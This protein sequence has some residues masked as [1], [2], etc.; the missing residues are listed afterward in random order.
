MSTARI[1]G[2]FI[3]QRYPYLPKILVADTNPWWQNKTAVK[4]DY[5]SGGVAPEYTHTDWGGVYD[6]L[7]GGIVDGE[8]E[9][10]VD[11]SKRVNGT[12]SDLTSW[13]PL[14][15]IHPTNQWFSGGPV[16]LASA[17][18]GDRSWLTF[19]ASQSGHADYPPNPPIPWWNCRRGW[20]PVELMYAAG[21]KEGTRNRRRPVLDNEPHYENRYNNG[22]S[23]N[24]YWNASDIRV[25]SWQT[26]SLGSAVVLSCYM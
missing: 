21:E 2:N 1:F 4:A 8:H 10:A 5:T 7:A 15:T 22:K 16:A 6:E 20:E 18:L 13:E 12:Q 19:D 26:V 17:F 3:G 9:S 25:G 23:A 11:G 24:A 14:I